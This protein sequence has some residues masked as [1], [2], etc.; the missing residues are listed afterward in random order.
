MNSLLIAL[1]LLNAPKDAGTDVV[2]LVDGPTITVNGKKPTPSPEALQEARRKDFKEKM[3][4]LTGKYT[5]GFGETFTSK[6]FFS[7]QKAGGDVE[8][9]IVLFT[10]KTK[11]FILLFDYVRDQEDNVFRIL[12]DDFTEQPEKSK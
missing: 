11:S 4:G 7:N 10:S 2:Q 6:I 8:I 1:L 5:E 3:V 12:P 9:V